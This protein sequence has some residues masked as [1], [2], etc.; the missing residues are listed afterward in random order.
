MADYTLSL[1]IEADNKAAAPLK[2]V[3]GAI[4]D[5]GDAAAPLTAV[6]GA[7]GDVGDAAGKTSEKT[8]GLG[9][10]AGKTSEKTLSL[11]EGLR[12]AALDSAVLSGGLAALVGAMKGLY[13]LG[14][15][16]ATVTQT[17]ESFA[18]LGMDL[19]ALRGAADGTVDDMTLM[20]STLTL[21]AGASDQLQAAFV[22]SADDLLRIAKAAN[23]LNPTLGD[24]TF[25]YESLAL[26]IKRGSPMILDNLGITLNIAAANEKYAAAIGKTVEQLTEEDK[27]IALLNATLDAGNRLIEQA[28]GTT[29]AAA[30][31]F[32]RFTTAATNLKNAMAQ[33][34][35]ASGGFFDNLGRGVD[36]LSKWQQ[37]LNLA[38]DQGLSPLAAQFEVL[39]EA[40]GASNTVFDD[41]RLQQRAAGGDM[42]A[43]RVIARQYQVE[44]FD[45]AATAGGSAAAF[46]QY[47][48]AMSLTA[49]A[50]SAAYAEQMDLRSALYDVPAAAQN[51]AAVW[52]Q[53]QQALQIQTDAQTKQY[54]I[55]NAINAAREAAAGAAIAFNDAAAALGEMTQAQFAAAQ[56]DALR[57]SLEAGVINSQQFAAAQ[58][59]VMIEFGMLSPSEMQAQAALNDLNAAYATGNLSAQ[60]YAAAIGTI[61]TGMDAAIAA[62]GAQ[63]AQ[64]AAVSAGSVAA[65]DAISG[66]G[67]AALDSTAYVET[68]VVSASKLGGSAAV[69]AGA[70]GSIT[71]IGGAASGASAEVDALTARIAGIPDKTVT[72]N[73]QVAESAQAA[74][75]TGA[76]AAAAGGS[77]SA[78]SAAGAGAGASS[79]FTQMQLGFSGIFTR[80]T[81]A[82]FGESGPERVVAQPLSNVTNNYNLAVNTPAAA[83][84]VIQDFNMMKAFLGR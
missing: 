47:Q 66:I 61:K 32:A 31:G 74:A 50:T 7:I 84:T 25:M 43:A 1:V 18:R 79:N 73:V 2:A 59:A 60:E 6:A 44:L 26:G 55:A 5:I 3:A 19:G 39:R 36:G 80:P 30:D 77:A 81:F 28:G 65:A 34:A 24:T 12:K 57:A 45:I 22:T 63:V 16:G 78:A 37:A 67:S 14:K 33:S 46:A 35:V 17:S 38:R 52:G 4:G 49:Q 72:I 21:A 41:M 27:K 29:A 68:I 64:L 20:S 83:A 69:A 9:D 56:I 11:G 75:Y 40:A 23:A 58:Q 48:T 8:E 10:A 51:S 62:E 82:V 54:E 53:Y 42:E 15:V 70:A 71:A 76:G 13:E